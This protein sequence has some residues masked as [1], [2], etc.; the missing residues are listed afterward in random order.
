MT[1]RRGYCEKKHGFETFGVVNSKVKFL[2]AG[3]ALVIAWAR[4]ITKRRWGIV[5]PQSISSNCMRQPDV[6][7]LIIECMTVK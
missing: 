3:D 7:S 4:W 2:S 6:P 5:Q 1:G